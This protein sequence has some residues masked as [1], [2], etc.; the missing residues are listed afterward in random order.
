VLHFVNAACEADT[1]A[2]AY[3]VDRPDPDG[4]V[5]VRGIRYRDRL[6]RRGDRWK[7]VSRL[8][9]SQWQYEVA[10]APVMPI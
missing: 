3:L 1:F 8:H 2:V 7:I 4:M 6:E 5:I 10:G 9:S